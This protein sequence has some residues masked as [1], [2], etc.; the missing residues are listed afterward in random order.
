MPGATGIRKQAL[1][2]GPARHHHGMKLSWV[3]WNGQGLE[4]VVNKGPLSLST[5][6]PQSWH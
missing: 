3:V 4:E 2:G 1:V 6:W 5:L